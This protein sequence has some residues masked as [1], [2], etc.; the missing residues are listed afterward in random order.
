MLSFSPSILRS[1][2]SQ[3]LKLSALYQFDLATVEPETD[4]NK[5]KDEISDLG[6]DRLVRR[7][8]SDKVGGVMVCRRYSSSRGSSSSSLICSGFGGG[9]ILFYFFLVVGCGCHIEVVAGGVVVK[10]DVAG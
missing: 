10:V 5:S 8:K 4:T 7:S 3:T 6:H 1:S 9:L 2:N